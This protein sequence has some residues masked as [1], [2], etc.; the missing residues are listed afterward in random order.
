MHLYNRLLLIKLLWISNKGS[1]SFKL[2]L[3]KKGGGG[4]LMGLTL[5][6]VHPGFP[7]GQKYQ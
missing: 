1:E 3:K 6:L 5:H 7:S 2:Q 4:S